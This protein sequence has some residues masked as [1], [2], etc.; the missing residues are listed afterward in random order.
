MSAW[1]FALFTFLIA[2]VVAGLLLQTGDSAR[3]LTLVLGQLAFGAPA[4]AIVTAVAVVARQRVR[5]KS[6]R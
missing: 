6:H 1:R 3:A 2:D 5:R 4:A